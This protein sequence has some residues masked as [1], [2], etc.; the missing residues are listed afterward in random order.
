M[1][2][3]RLHGVTALQGIRDA[4]GHQSKE[5]GKKTI[6]LLDSIINVYG[7]VPE[8]AEAAIERYGLMPEGNNAETKAKYEYGENILSRWPAWKDMSRVRNGQKS[9]TQPTLSFN[10]GDDF[11]IPARSAPPSSQHV[12]CRK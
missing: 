1:E 10:G 11:S 3:E 12:I 4:N 7:D 5:S 9:L 8:C 2:T 6:A